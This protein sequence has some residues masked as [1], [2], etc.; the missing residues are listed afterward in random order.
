MI[1]YTR[2]WTQV[3]NSIQ[4]QAFIPSILFSHEQMAQCD[5]WF[6]RTIVQWW[7]KGRIWCTPAVLV[8]LSFT[9]HF[10]DSRSVKN[11]RISGEMTQKGPWKE[12]KQWFVFE[13][14][15]FLPLGAYALVHSS[16][17]W[18]G[19]CHYYTELYSF[20]LRHYFSFCFFFL[21]FL[22]LF[23]LPFFLL[24]RFYSSFFFCS[25]CQSYSNIL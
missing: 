2:Q 8:H 4:F 17:L 11:G 6:F 9:S 14:S 19:N 22:F 21:F 23:F 20:R 3:Q 13:I 24:A 25:F 5:Y 1:S 16:A 12:G 10:T 18:R 15:I 7:W